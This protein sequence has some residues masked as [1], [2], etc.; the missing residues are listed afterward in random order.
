[1]KI[2][3]VVPVLCVKLGGGNAERAIQLTA[4]MQELGHE[5]DILTLNIGDISNQIDRLAPNS[6]HTI[7]CRNLRF[8]IPGRGFLAVLQSL[9][10]YDCIHVIGHWHLLGFCCAMFCKKFEIPYLFS[11]TGSLEVQ[12]RSRWL[13]H[14]VNA[15]FGKRY[16]RHASRH[17]AITA[18]EAKQFTSYG[19]DPTSVSVIPNGVHP[20]F[21]HLETVREPINAGQE[22]PGK[23]ILFSG[24]LNRIKGP[25]ILLSA[26]SLIAD[27]FIDLHLVLIGSDEGE[28]H[29]LKQMAVNAKLSERVHFLGFVEGAIKQKVF[30]NALLTVIP[31][32]SEAMSIVALE[33][34]AV[35]TP[36]MSTNKCGLEPLLN[37]DKRLIVSATAEA[38][39][40]SVTSLL[41]QQDK[42]LILGDILQAKV[43]SEYLWEHQ[44]K[45]LIALARDAQ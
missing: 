13:K 39:A 12:G 16:V 26:F 17:I 21:G 8:F 30:T 32:R 34:G 7:K 44:S 20:S 2:L 10:K 43:M 19:V 15:L 4:A 33:S 5:A 14:C 27:V 22:L 37:Y 40:A 24:R 31:S 42:L 25:D 23:Y 45:A 9:K 35:G 18:E 11:P 38:I 6:V 41:H 36:V 29:S 3:T 28:L 1:M